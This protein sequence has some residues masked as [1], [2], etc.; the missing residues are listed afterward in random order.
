MPLLHPSRRQVLRSLAGG[1]LLLPGI[2][3][4]LLAADESRAASADPLR[5][6]MPHHPAKAKR[7]ILLFSTGGVSHMDTF[8]HKPKLFKADGKMLGVGGGL[9]LEKRPLL[10]PR[11]QFRP[12]GK[13]G[14][15]VSD[16]FPHI[17]QQMDNI[18]L[19]RS[20]TTDSNEHF[21]ATLAIHTGSFFVPRPSLARWLSYGLG[22]MNQNLPSFVVLAPHLPYAGTQVWANDFLPAYHQGTRVLPGA[23]PIPNVRRQPATAALQEME[24]AWPTSSIATICGATATISSWRH[25]SRHLRPLFR[26]NS[27]PP[28][29]S[30][31]RNFR[32]G[33]L[34]PNAFRR[35]EISVDE[36]LNSTVL[37]YPL[38]QY[39]FCAPDEGAAAV[40][41][42]RADIAHKYTDKP[43]YVR[44]CEIRTR[45]YGAYEVHA[46]F[47]PLDGDPSPTVYASKAA[48]EAAGIG[49]EDV[50][51]AQLQD[52]DAGNE[53]IHMA[54]TGLCADGDQEKLIADGETEIHGSIPVNTDGGLIANGE[55]IGA[56]GLRQMHELVRQLRGEAGDRQV[57]GNPRVG[58][59][60]VYGAPGTAS[61]TILSL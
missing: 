3:A 2:L 21:Q 4:D 28:P 22:T 18:C 40:V 8:D 34:N 29:P 37:N 46:T 31:C 26:C 15:L 25:G 12:G 41:M 27:P 30:I 58:L 57:P 16:L 13:C 47:A 17:R 35:K 56:S 60:Q 39:M 50:D 33:A 24:L 44:A 53:V 14:T 11:W 51:V 7:V 38:T 10:K 20:M 42:C 9:S 23:E 61:A 48:Y 32:N 1:S 5:T 36:I 54:E 43:V 19:I 55:P 59:A 52:T 6:R 45:R 49:P